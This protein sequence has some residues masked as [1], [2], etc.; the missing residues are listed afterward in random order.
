MTS[1]KRSLLFVILMTTTTIIT[2][3]ACDSDKGDLADAA[4]D[5]DCQHFELNKMLLGLHL[6]MSEN[7]PFL[8]RLGCVWISV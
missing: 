5:D 1:I 6:C 2:A 7:F 4:I 3:N 8:K